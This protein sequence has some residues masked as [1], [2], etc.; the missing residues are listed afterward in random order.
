[1]KDGIEQILKV[2]KYSSD[3]QYYYNMEDNEIII[4]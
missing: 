4:M 2:L 1:M 3:F